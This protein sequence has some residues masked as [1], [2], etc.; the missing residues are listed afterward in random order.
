MRVLCHILLLICKKYDCIVDFTRKI[1]ECLV[2]N[3]MG[4][5]YLS[6]NSRMIVGCFLLSQLI[7]LN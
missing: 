4:S 3:T 6:V 2:K 7:G 1:E 5:D